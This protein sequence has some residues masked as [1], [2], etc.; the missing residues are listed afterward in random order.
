[1][2]TIITTRANELVAPRHDR[3]PAILKQVDEDQWLSD[4]PLARGE[5]DQILAS[6]PHGDMTAYLV[7]SRINNTAAEDDDRLICP[8]TTL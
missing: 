2:Y 4:V 3:M 5:V 1:M 6:Y 8:L 7:S